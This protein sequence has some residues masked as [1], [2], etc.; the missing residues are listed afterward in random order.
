MLGEVLTMQ[1]QQRSSVTARWYLVAQLLH[2]CGCQ[3]SLRDGSELVLGCQ[4]LLVTLEILAK[5]LW[6]FEAVWS[7]FR[8]RSG[9]RC[10]ELIAIE[11]LVLIPQADLALRWLAG[12][13]SQLSSHPPAS[14]ADPQTLQINQSVDF[15]KISGYS[16]RQ[17]CASGKIWCLLILFLHD[18]SLM[19]VGSR[20][21]D[22]EVRHIFL[23]RSAVTQVLHRFATIVLPKCCKGRAGKSV[24]LLQKLRV[25]RFKKNKKRIRRK[26]R[27]TWNTS[28]W[29]EFHGVMERN[30]VE[31]NWLTLRKILC[32]LQVVLRSYMVFMSVWIKNTLLCSFC[33]CSLRDSRIHDT[34]ICK[35]GTDLSYLLMLLVIRKRT[36]YMKLV[37]NFCEEHET[38]G[39]HANTHNASANKAD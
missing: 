8:V 19:E 4:V 35:P 24:W 27:D 12:L 3:W 17:T 25:V 29:S 28:S 1:D 38:V 23:D 10:C 14:L 6:V 20:S 15:M 26:T 37:L 34:L 22:F 39:D 11:P 2:L 16:Q 31:S 30:R 5:T 7:R 9:L 21:C 36:A 13:L 33:V 18:S 32:S